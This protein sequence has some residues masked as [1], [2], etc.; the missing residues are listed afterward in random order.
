MNSVRKNLWSILLIVAVWLI[1]SSPYILKGLVPFPSTYL[2]TFFPPWSATYGM[3]VKNS[4]MPDV[5]T[6]IYPWKTLTI[7]RWKAGQIPLWNPYSF[8]GTAHAANYQTAVFSPVQALFFL[9]PFIDAWSIMILIQPLLA[10]I[11]MYVLLR[12]FNR[13]GAASVI[14]SLAFMFCGFMV[15][16]MAYGTLGY[17]ALWLPLIFYAIHSGWERPTVWKYAMVSIGLA[18]S[19]LSGHFQISLY[20]S[21][22]SC[23]Y[24]AYRILRTKEYATGLRFALFFLLGLLIAAPQ[25]LLSFD[26]YTKSVRMTNYVKAEIIPWEYLITLLAP[27]FYGNPVTRNDWF[28][29]YAEWAGYIG[30]APLLLALFSVSKKRKQD[31]WFFILCSGAALLLALPTPFTDFLFMIKLPVLSTS[32]ASR[33]IILVSFS[34]ATLSAY[35][36][37]HLNERWKKCTLLPVFRFILFVLIIVGGIWIYMVVARPLPA[38][39]LAIAKRNFILPTALTVASLAIFIAGFV[40]KAGMSLLAPFLLCLV[41]AFDVSRFATKWMPFDPKEYMYPKEKSLQFLESHAGYDRVFGNIGNEVASMFHLSVVEGYDAMYQGRYAEFI[42]AASKGK[43]IEGDRS[44]VQFDKH[45]LYKKEALQLLGV[46]YIYHRVRD[47]RAPWVFPYWEYGAMRQVYNDSVYWIYEYTDAYPRAFLASSYT[48][49][50]DKQDIIDALFAP[51]FDRRD[52]LVL[53]ETP[54]LEPQ[55]GPGQATIRSYT[56]NEVIIE[57]ESSVPKLLFLSDVFDS[58][59]KAYIDGT[60]SHLYRADYDFRAVAVPAGSHTVRFVYSPTSLRIG[61]LLFSIALA[62]IIGLL[63]KTIYEHRVI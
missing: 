23:G 49:A 2:V 26:A 1:F 39:K 35:G 46:R 29:H 18:L 37:D 50:V 27:D 8:S 48:V 7:E 33:I 3:P 4:A 61:I 31:E 20:V 43:V 55:P 32:A 28:G 36:F 24:I 5:I 22:L 14:G 47:G 45:G 54:H 60:A 56:P 59:W 16:W 12:S 17:A 34:L 9:L 19:F 11:F 13:S 51:E 10:G 40:K 6:Q 58:G 53:E 57:T 15:T 30:V 38:D 41:V 44:V 52:T 21:L 63:G 25:L 42:N 62:G